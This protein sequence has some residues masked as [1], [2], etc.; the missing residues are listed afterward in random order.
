[1]GQNRTFANK[2][3]NGDSVEECSHKAPLLVGGGGE[4]RRGGSD[5]QCNC[6][7]ARIDKDC[8]SFSLGS[9]P[10]SISGRTS[11]TEEMQTRVAVGEVGGEGDWEIIVSAS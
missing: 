4:E 5:Q 6:N 11:E 3:A 10:Q 8:F 1:M 2:T 7:D 9:P